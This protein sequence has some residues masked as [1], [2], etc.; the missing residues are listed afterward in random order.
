MRGRESLRLALVAL[1]ALGSAL[2]FTNPRR[3]P[4]GVGQNEAVV[5]KCQLHENFVGETSGAFL[6]RAGRHYVCAGC[7]ADLGRMKAVLC[8]TCSSEQF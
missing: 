5:V 4:R 3:E 6:C 1:P 7:G 8:K 2:S